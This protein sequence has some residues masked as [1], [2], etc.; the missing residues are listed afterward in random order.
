MWRI[1]GASLERLDRVEA[2]HAPGGIDAG[3]EAEEHGA[4]PGRQRKTRE[5]M[6]QV[7]VAG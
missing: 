5:L 4:A 3:E 1:I 7:G 6:A 2:R